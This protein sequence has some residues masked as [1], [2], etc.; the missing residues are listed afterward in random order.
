[1]RLVWP[2]MILAGDIG[3]TKCTLALFTG[4]NRNLRS[5]YRLSLATAGFASPESLLEEFKSRAIRAG[6][7]LHPLASAAFGVAGVIADDQAVSGNLPWVVS[8]AEL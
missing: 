6:Y 3:G 1:M 2:R 5:L 4:E 7:S 8:R